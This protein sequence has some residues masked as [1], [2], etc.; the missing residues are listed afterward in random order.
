MRP[1]R[2]SGHCILPPQ[3]V[4]K[5]GTMQNT[6][7]AL[8]QADENENRK[9]KR[10]NEQIKGRTLDAEVLQKREAAEKEKEVIAEKEREKEY[11]ELW[12][13]FQTI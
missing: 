12:K 2:G 4:A 5:L 7:N 6:N 1:T 13:L 11:W 9:K 3:F 8:I 10:S